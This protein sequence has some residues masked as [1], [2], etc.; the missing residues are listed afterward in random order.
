MSCVAA[1]A[2]V[3][4]NTLLQFFCRCVLFVLQL[5]FICV[6]HVL[7]VSLVPFGLDNV[8]LPSVESQEEAYKMARQ[9]PA[10]VVSMRQWCYGELEFDALMRQLD[11]A[12]S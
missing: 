6:A 10:G 5:C 3:R 4:H 12:V 9:V 7:Q 1:A 8:H 11:N 2:Q